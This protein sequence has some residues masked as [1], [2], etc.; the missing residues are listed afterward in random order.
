MS[1]TICVP[2]AVPSERHSS[3][4][5]VPSLASKNSVPPT[6]VRYRGYECAARV[7]VLDHLRAAGR[8]VR[9][10]QLNAVGPVVGRE[11]QRPAHVGV[12]S[13]DYELALPGLMSLKQ[14]R[15]ARR[16][17][18]RTVKAFVLP[19]FDWKLPSVVSVDS[20]NGMR[21]AGNREASAGAGDR[22]AAACSTS[23]N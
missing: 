21:A 18:G 17:T 14:V 9:T 6:L 23:A 5:W 11:E 1:L 19:L 16:Q 13:L 2:A 3:T 20:G 8:P 4:P 12:V 22:G 10:P 7:D 15:R